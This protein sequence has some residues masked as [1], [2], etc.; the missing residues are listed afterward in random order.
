MSEWGVPGVA[1]GIV[2]NNEVIYLKGFGVKCRG[3]DEAVTPDTLFPLAS[4]TKAFTTTAL[5]M[6]VDE[7]KMAWDDLVHKH[8]E[9]FHLADPLADR[10]VTVRDETGSGRRP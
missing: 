5:A 9:S 4:C 6:L 2:R 1:I 7:G 3:R 8:L 10:D